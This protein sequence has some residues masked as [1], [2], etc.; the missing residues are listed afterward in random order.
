MVQMYTIAGRQVG[1]HVLAI[2]TLTTTIGGAWLAMRGGDKPA[3]AQQG[4][5]M[6]AKSKDE[7]KFIK[8]FV[9]KATGEKKQ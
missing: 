2:A 1:S 6:N 8:N 5:P 3:E 9:D 4:P 7:E